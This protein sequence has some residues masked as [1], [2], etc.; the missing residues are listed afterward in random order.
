MNALTDML[1]AMAPM[2]MQK[3]T[4]N[5]V[6]FLIESGA[7]TT[8]EWAETS[9]SVNRG[10]LQL[11]A[12]EGRLLALFETESMETV[13]DFLGWNED[14]VRAAVSAGRL[15]AVEISG[16]LRFPTWQFH[17]ASPTNLLPGLTKIF[18]VISPRWHWQIAAAFVA[19]PQSSLVAE[20]RKTP[21][22]WLRDGGDVNEVTQLI[23]SDDW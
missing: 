23:E 10:S 3:L 2:S 16:R 5:E 8:E 18:S 1:L 14:A 11:G 22:E 15:Y 4:E 7:F 17:A 13:T 9:A 19:T 12:A 21:V 6:R 20:G